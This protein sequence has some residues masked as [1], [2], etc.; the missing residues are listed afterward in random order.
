MTNQ[1]Q[2]G[3]KP[4]VREPG[5][6]FQTYTAGHGIT[7][8]KQLAVAAEPVEIVDDGTTAV[9]SEINDAYINRARALELKRGAAVVVARYSGKAELFYKFFLGSLVL[10]GIDILITAMPSM[11]LFSYLDPELPIVGQGVAWIFAFL[12]IPFQITLTDLVEEWQDRR[13]EVGI[14]II[15][16]FFGISAYFWGIFTNIAQVNS[17]IN[18]ALEAGVYVDPLVQA[19]LYVLFAVLEF[20]E[21]LA[22]YFIIRVR[23]A[24]SVLAAY[25]QP[26]KPRFG[27]GFGGS[28]L[29]RVIGS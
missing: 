20:V 7:G 28:L 19:F 27:F 24:E 22:I 5:Q 8:D 12:T 3:K 11:P 13:E 17:M 9:Q 1:K 2:T 15:I 26:V 16:G 23:A 10:I 29:E 18:S 21:I 25:G 14:V 4:L 6:P